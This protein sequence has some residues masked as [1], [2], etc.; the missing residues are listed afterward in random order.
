MYHIGDWVVRSSDG[1]CKIADI[2]NPDFVLDSKKMYYQLVSASDQNGKIYVPVESAQDMMRPEMSSV[3]ANELILQIPEIKESWIV[4]E[5]ERQNHYKQSND[6]KQ[7]IGII[8]LIYQRKKARQ[9]QGKKT[10]A[11]DGQYFNLAESRLYSELEHA[12]GKSR[13]DV[14]SMIKKICEKE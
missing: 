3:E 13:T 10:T 6:P 1:L 12:L 9:A 7:L 14:E 5:R 2:T 4:S 11:V 8:K